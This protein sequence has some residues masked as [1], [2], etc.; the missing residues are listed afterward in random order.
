[1]V[2]IENIAIN[3]LSGGNWVKSAKF[4]ARQILD[5]RSSEYKKP[6]E[7]GSS[8]F[9]ERD[10]ET[11]SLI[12]ITMNVSSSCCKYQN[13][14]KKLWFLLLMHLKRNDDGRTGNLKW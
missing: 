12:V 6:G 3:F 13:K 10:S 8:V 14:V 11:S 9:I 2:T 7:H 1:M 5:S 4:Q